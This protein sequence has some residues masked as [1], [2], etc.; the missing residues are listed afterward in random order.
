MLHRVTKLKQNSSGKEL[1]LLH[2][3]LLK[4]F[5][6]IS[7]FVLYDFIFY[8]VNMFGNHFIK[9]H[10]SFI[11]NQFFSCLVILLGQVVILVAGALLQGFASPC[12]GGTLFQNVWKSLYFLFISLCS[13]DIQKNSLLQVRY[14]YEAHHYI[15]FNFFGHNIK[16]P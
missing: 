5:T 14:I 2:V 15:F 8:K 9:S 16:K 10:K 13:N 12:A 6:N 11:C 4:H 7:K 3:K 1:C